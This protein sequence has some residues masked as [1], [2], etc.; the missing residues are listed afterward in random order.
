MITSITN[1]RVQYVSLLQTQRR[2]RRKANQFVI[3]GV[4]LSVEALDNN[5]PVDEVFYTLDFANSDTGTALL[6]RFSRAGA[7]LMAVD[8]AVM[9]HISDTQTPQGILAVLPTFSPPLPESPEFILVIDG[10]AD[11]GNMGTIMRTAVG[12]KVPLVIV[13]AG[14]VDLLNPKVVRS[15]MGAH[16]YLPVTQMSWEGMEPLQR[17]CFLSGVGGQ[18]YAVLPRELDAAQRPDRQRRGARRE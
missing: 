17:S 6:D 15:A 10:I 3:E 9:Q 13:T 18:W 4:K 12:A 11:P 1:D 14:T 7:R 16:F 2:A 8:E 5:A